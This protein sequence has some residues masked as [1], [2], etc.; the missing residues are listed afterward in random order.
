MG[1]VSF[2]ISQPSSRE[3]RMNES[4]FILAVHQLQEEFLILLKVD[5]IEKNIICDFITL[6]WK[7]REL[8]LILWLCIPCIM[9]CYQYMVSCWQMLLAS[10]RDLDG[11]QTEI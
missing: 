3:D 6:Q 7:I 4:I 1:T 10:F 5:A 8:C 9:M 11:M 2:M